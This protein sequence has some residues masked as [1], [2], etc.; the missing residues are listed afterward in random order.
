MPIGAPRQP[1]QDLASAVVAARTIRWMARENPPPAR[2]VAGPLDVVWPA[3]LDLFDPGFGTAAPSE[4]D[5]RDRQLRRTQP[6]GHAGLPGQRDGDHS[7]A[8]THRNADLHLTFA[9]RGLR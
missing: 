6:L 8:G 2:R 3:D 1:R 9:A 5:V 7:R 4:A